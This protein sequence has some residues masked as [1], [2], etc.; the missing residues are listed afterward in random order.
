VDK[1]TCG[2]LLDD[3]LEHAR[4]NA[5]ASTAKV[6]QQVVEAN[7][8]IFLASKGHGVEHR[9]TQGV[10]AKASCGRSERIDL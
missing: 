8:A 9:R 10:P 7:I 1:V 6:W 2:E 4:H 3:L 5:K